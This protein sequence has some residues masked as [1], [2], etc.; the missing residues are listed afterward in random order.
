MKSYQQQ[1]RRDYS[2]ERTDYQAPHRRPRFSLAGT[3][4]TLSLIATGG[5][6]MALVFVGYGI[7]QT[8]DRFISQITDIFTAPQPEPQVDVRS[9]VLQQVRG[10]SEL[11]T[12]I[13]A[14]QAV[15]PTSRDRT[16]G[17][18]TIGRTTLL[19]IAYGEVRAGVD[20][21]EIADQD[22]TVVGDQLRLQ[23]PPPRILDSK[24]DVNRSSVYDYDRGFMGLGPDS[25]PE[26]Q[27]LAQQE[28]LRQIIQT[29]CS[30]GILQEAN[31]RA[32]QAVTTLLS[33]AGYQQIVVETQSPPL[34]TCAAPELSNQPMSSE[35][36]TLEDAPDSELNPPTTPEIPVFEVPM[37]PEALPSFE[38][39]L[40]S[41]S[42]TSN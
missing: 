16:V 31:N 32:Q 21:S 25:A 35:D 8:G 14:M 12:A 23:L 29:A 11:T 9:L 27:T 22:M 7:W 37:S 10:A 38:S 3:L 13:F 34:E 41:D 5:A 40:T 33:T 15:V 17:G 18:Y 20:L 6:V 39:P 28:T 1:E 26:L 2:L 19:Y 30:Q 42:E 36:S 4:R 24:I